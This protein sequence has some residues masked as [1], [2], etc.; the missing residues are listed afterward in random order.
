MNY[1]SFLSN[2]SSRRKANPIRMTREL[3]K[4]MSSIIMLSGGLPNADYFP[5]KTASITLV[6]GTTIEIG[7]QM[8]KR[9][10][11]YSNPEGVHELLSWVEDLQ[12]KLHNP[13]TAKYTP[14]KGQ[15]KVIITPGSQDG[16]S[17]VW[18][19]QFST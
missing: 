6:D 10:L 18:L 3:E 17:K 9:A 11:Q 16:L 13:P 15:M 2:I 12:L 14:E 19:I 7:E 5:M 1:S 4:K 8:M